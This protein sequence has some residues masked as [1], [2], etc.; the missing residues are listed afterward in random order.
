[1]G[2][3][4]LL[5]ETSYYLKRGCKKTWFS[6]RLIMEVIKLSSSAVKLPLNFRCVLLGCSE[7]GKSSFIK[8][9]IKNKSKLFQGEYEKIIYCSPNNSARHDLEYREMLQKW[10]E[11]AEMKFYNHII[12]ENELLEIADTTSNRLLLFIDDFSLEI[13]QTDMV[14]SLYTRLSSHRSID[15][16]I[17]LHQGGSSKSG[18]G[19]FYQAVLSNCNFI[20][21]FRNISNRASIGEISKRIYPYANN[22]LMRCLNKS[23]DITGMHS[24]ICIDASLSNELNHNYGI[25]TNIFCENDMPIILFKNPKIY[26]GSH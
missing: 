11:P 19:R 6:S 15:S 18:G 22:F 9:L 16:C 17:S 1:M 24:Y 5:C 14:Y 4:C 3:N 13:F 23:T 20:V 21:L 12:E 25:R 7:S 10:A 26:R 2:E 8:Q